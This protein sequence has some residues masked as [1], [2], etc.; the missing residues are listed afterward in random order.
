MRLTIVATTDSE[1]PDGA[2]DKLTYQLIGSRLAA[3]NMSHVQ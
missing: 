3:F 2:R 1:G